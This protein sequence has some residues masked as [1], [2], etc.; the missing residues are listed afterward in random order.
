LASAVQSNIETPARNIE[1]G[2]CRAEFPHQYAIRSWYSG[3]NIPGKPPLFMVYCGG[4]KRYNETCYGELENNFPGYE[5]M[6][7]HSAEN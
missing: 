7:R 1:P 5:V 3:A 4:F 2:I 6:A